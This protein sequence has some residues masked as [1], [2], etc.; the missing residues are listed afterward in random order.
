MNVRF[1]PF[2][3]MACLLLASS[4][5]AREDVSEA[6][7]RR[8]LEKTRL[9]LRR[10]GFKTDVADFDFS[11]P[12]QL[13]D[14]ETIRA[15]AITNQ[16]VAPFHN[17]PDVMESA[18][19]NKAIVIWQQRALIRPVLSEPDI[20]HELSWDDFRD[21]IKRRQPQ[22]DAACAAILAGP[23]QFDLAASDGDAMRLPHLPFLKELTQTLDERSLLALHD[24]WR[25][26]AWTNLLAA[27][28]LVTA[29][30]P[31]PAEVS[32]R[33]R[34]D[35]AKWVSHALWQALQTNGW[36]DRQLAALQ[37]EWE[38]AD[39]LSRLPEIPAFQSAGDAQMLEDDKAAQKKRAELWEDETSLLLFYR[40]RQVEF[41][42]AVR[43]VSWLSMRALPGVTNEPCFIPEHH[44]L[45][46]FEFN[47][48]S[49]RA[50][51]QARDRAVGFLARAAQAEAERRI[52]ITALA[53]ERFRVK[54]GNYPE[55]V[56]ALAPDFLPSPPIDFMNGQPLRYWLNEDGHFLLYSVGL[57][58]VD[59]GGRMESPS[60]E[61]DRISTLTNPNASRP[62]SDVVWPLPASSADITVLRVAQAEGK[63]QADA[64]QNTVAQ[65]RHERARIARAAAMK[66]RLAEKPALGPEP[67]YHDTPLSV[68]AI[69]L[70]QIEELDGAPEDPAEAIRFIGA[71]AV[72][73][74]LEWMTHPE[75]RRQVE[76]YPDGTSIVLAWSALGTNG[77]S[78]IPE[79]ARR[80][81]RPEQTADD[82]SFWSESA[83]A[84]LFWAR[85]PSA[86]CWPLPLICKANT[87]SGNSCAILR[88]SEPMALP[89]FQRSFNGSIILMTA[90]ATAL[91]PPWVESANTRT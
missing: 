12:P 33:L 91:S 43:A 39:F 86:P 68:W 15:S 67:V 25:D 44:S 41:R 81:N 46:L 14:R 42:N 9:E 83:A 35:D 53:L 73:F 11:F 59:N 60:A 65:A 49:R 21:W 20:P 50:R 28:R 75:T 74:L 63:A 54:F 84:F 69:G 61:G 78:A 62:E 70:S 48:V 32:H 5:P 88:I 52:I 1:L 87:F 22:L 18:A 47:M 37:H 51:T 3:W 77:K 79:L 34:F 45:G 56:Q 6:T 64:H 80:L 38:S 40:D 16:R 29:W 55:T 82:E 7:A 26:A 57:D 4:A 27:T 36:P 31:E 66:Q 19:T 30:N 90:S 10:H 8:A 85:M 58:C 23:I 76:D 24:G 71:N 72:P 89:L 17:H 2:S 13:R